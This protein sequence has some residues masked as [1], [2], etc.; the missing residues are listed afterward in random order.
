[1]PYDTTEY[2]LFNTLGFAVMKLK[3]CLGTFNSSASDVTIY[4]NV[5]PLTLARF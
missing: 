5:Q 1:M 2:S 3:P 4:S